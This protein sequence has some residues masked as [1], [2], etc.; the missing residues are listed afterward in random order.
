MWNS[1]WLVV[2]V[3]GGLVSAV[4]QWAQAQ[5]VAALPQ[6]VSDRIDEL[7]QEVRIL[8]R[9]REIEKDTAYVRKVLE[10]GCQRASAVARATLEEVK[11][12]VGLK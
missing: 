1:R 10:E 11:K 12:Q 7:E 3:V 6:T 5:D 2:T 8:K 9:R 4:A